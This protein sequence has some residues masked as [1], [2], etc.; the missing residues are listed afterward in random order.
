MLAKRHGVSDYTSTTTSTS[1]VQPSGFIYVETDRYL[2]TPKPSI[3]ASSTQ[4]AKVQALK[5]WANEPLQELKFLRRIVENK[6]NPGDGFNAG[7][8]ALM[9]GCVIWAPFHTSPLL[10]NLYLQIAEEVTGPLLWER[11]VGFRYL[12][13]GKEEGEVERLVK[14]EDWLSNLLRLREG[15]KGRGWSFDVGVDAHQDGV[16]VV[17]V[18]ADM[19]GKVRALE[20]SSPE[21]GNVR[22]ILNHL[23]KPA[24]SSP[25][26]PWPSFPRYT[27]ALSRLGADKNIFMKLSGA[28]NEFEPGPTPPAVE[29]ILDCLY[30]YLKHVSRAFKSRVMF[31][32]DWPVCN[33]G[34]PMGEQSWELWREVVESWLERKGDG[35]E[36]VWWRAGCEAYGIE[37]LGDGKVQS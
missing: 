25:A 9:L 37:G 15:R 4:D 20:S 11:V 2:P 30:P 21:A 22:F 19:V 23:C 26:N 31:G 28:F 36:D 6:P 17:E 13:Q 7:D 33:I 29:D 8:G 3:S 16:A 32:S 1:P 34:G 14:T 18:V 5:T 10:F 27:A 12:L 24:I 35:E